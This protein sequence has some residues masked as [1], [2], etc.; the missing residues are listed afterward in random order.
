MR[1]EQ[2]TD[3]S[4]DDVAALG[5]LLLQL[6]GE[7]SRLPTLDSVK[8]CARKNYLIVARDESTRRIVG[9]VMVATISDFDMTQCQIKK[10][11]VDEG[12][13]R[14]GIARQLMERAFTYARERSATRCELYTNT[15]RNPVACELYE[16]LGFEPRANQVRYVLPL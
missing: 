16:A 1:I 11:I 3:V 12:H 7:S 6:T 13:R 4:E 9:T 14:Q 8:K 10:L 2:L 15:I 5:S